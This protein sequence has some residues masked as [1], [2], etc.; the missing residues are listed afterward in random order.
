[1]P[2]PFRDTLPP[3]IARYSGQAVEP[4][5]G[6][7]VTYEEIGHWL[8]IPSAWRKGLPERFAPRLTAPDFRKQI[9]LHLKEFPEW[10]PLLHPKKDSEFPQ[11]RN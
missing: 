6:H 3:R 2:R 10:E 9:E 1:M 8:T 4:K 7:P 5:A 11:V